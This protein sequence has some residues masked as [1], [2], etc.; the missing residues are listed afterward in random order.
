MAIDHET[1]SD[2]NADDS[3]YRASIHK[4]A[5]QDA[6]AVGLVARHMYRFRCTNIQCP[7][8]MALHWLAFCAA[9]S[10]RRSYK[11][12]CG[13][14]PNP[15]ATA[16][17]QAISGDQCQVLVIDASSATARGCTCDHCSGFE[18]NC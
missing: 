15:G 11:H 1:L 10:M 4:Y 17:M 6:D 16:Q 3:V 2:W 18:Y 9:A 12:W 7:T 8:M 14:K 5:D 13:L